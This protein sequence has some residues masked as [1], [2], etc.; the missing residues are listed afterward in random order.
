MILAS[1]GNLRH[2]HQR[3][4]PRLLRRRRARSWTRSSTV[5]TAVR[6]RPG[7]A[8]SSRSATGF[9]TDDVTAH[10]WGH[11]YTQYTHGLIYQWQSGALNE[12]LRHLRRDGRPHQRTRRRYA[13]TTRAPPT[14]ARA[15]GGTPPPTL[16]ITG[17]T[18]A[19]SYPSPGLR[20]RAA[21]P[22]T[23][24]PTAMAIAVRA[25]TGACAA[26]TS[27]V[28][29][30]IAIIDWTLL[31]GRRTTSAAPE[32]ARG[33]ALRRRRDGHHLRGSGERPASILGASAAIA[34]VEV[35]NADGETIKAGLPADATITL[36]VGTDDS[37]RWLLGEDTTA[38]GPGRRCSATCGTPAASATPARSPTPSSTPA[39]PPT[40]AAYTPT[41]A[42]TNHAYALLV[43]GGTYNG[44]TISGIGLTKAAHI[45][46]RAKTAYQVPATDFADHADAIEQSCADLIG[47]RPRDLLTGGHVRRSHLRGRLRPGRPRRCSR[48]RCGPP[49]TSCNFQPLLAQDPP[50]LCPPA[51]RGR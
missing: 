36:D 43:D 21:A 27:G 26:V 31:P 41:P 28:G 42:S 46:F 45:Y 29:G 15:Y 51:H 40:A 25:P 11:A 22:F 3:L 48:S 19:G 13:R 35:T 44:Q 6:T 23:V 10:E 49:P 47:S 20:E 5:A 4:R 9:T 12:S 17:G 8:R 38:T 33:N 39:R 32:P 18:A 50:A 1:Q 30:K 37:L 34:S 7:T 16:T 2:L 24:G 14:T